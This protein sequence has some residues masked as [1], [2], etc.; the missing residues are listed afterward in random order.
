MRRPVSF[1]TILVALLAG[2]GATASPA[3][4]ATTELFVNNT[5]SCSD[6]GPGSAAQPFCTLSASAAAVTA[7]QTV[8]VTGSY[9][10][11]LTIGKSGTAGSP[12]TFRPAVDGDTSWVALTGTNAGI[13]VSGQHDVT[14]IGFQ[15][16]GVPTGTTVDV[17]N[18]TRVTIERIELAALDSGVSA[19][20]TAGVRLAS[21][22]DSALRSIRIKRDVRPAIAMDAATSGVVVTS[23]YVRVNDGSLHPGGI[24]IL[25]PHNSV[26]RS[27]VYYS[28]D[29]GI[30]VGAGATGTVLASDYV[31]GA[32]GTAIDN[33]GASGTAITNNNVANPCSTGIRVS[34]ASTGVSV[35]NNVVYSNDANP[36]GCDPAATGVGVGVYDAA[37]S[38]TTVDY[39]IVEPRTGKSLYAWTTPVA[40]L[41]AFRAV[42]GQGAH[43]L[44]STDPDARIDSG[45]SAAPGRQL[46]YFGKFPV[47]DP[48]VPNTGSGPITY[49]DRGARE[50]TRTPSAVLALTQR[51]GSEVTADASGS[52]PGWLPITSYTFD[53][54]D[55]TVVTQATPVAHHTFTVRGE[56]AVQ[57]TVKDDNGDLNTGA[58]KFITDGDGYVPVSPV[59]V[60][61]TRAKIGVDT[62]TPV[63]PGGTVTLQVAGANGLPADGVT[64]VTMNVTVTEPTANGFLSVYPD[65][66]SLPNASNLNWTPGLTVPNLVVVSVVNG[67][68]DFHNTSPGTVHVVADL[69]GYHSSAGGS[70]FA[71]LGPVRVLDTR[72]RIG[73]PTTTPI[74]PG[75]TLTL[76]VTGG[77]GVPAT[78]VTAVTM[79]VTVTQPAANGFLTVYPDGQAL[80]NASNLNWTPGLTAPNLVVVPVVNGKVAFHNTSPG[81]VHVVADLVGYYTTAGNGAVFHAQ[82]P[83]RALD[84]RSG[85]S[86]NPVGPGDLYELGV[87]G[88]SPDGAT[89][90]VLNV[91]V[92][93]PKDFGFLTVTGDFRQEKPN[94]SNLNWRPGQTVPNLVVVPLN[95]ENGRVRFYNT[96]SGSVHIVA[97][98]VGFYSR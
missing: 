84:T 10:E 81:T 53:F 46:D 9:A 54:G 37:V 65:G 25:G 32:L 51:P 69:V 36:N 76:Q 2:V 96:S 23:A 5:V 88:L 68:V 80:P 52:R 21:V 19:A 8:R 61:D 92:T 75:G 34:G 38:G 66:Q 78:G 42:S 89:A 27:V 28:V 31:T 85:P 79:N 11:H 95:P 93:E 82:S 4:A 20:A 43:D 67:K 63:A 62:T 22:T 83:Y 70:V 40:S 48:D 29:T 58:K 77:N 24:E 91:T 33:A 98:V 72:E 57:L 13:T 35:Q 87:G 55:G 18:S 97:D 26:V 90:V 15:I 45:N 12:V 16:Q 71:P 49:A 56:H 94:A 73:I 47:D 14:I 50:L 3:H 6:A 30:L 17:A 44:D 74:A 7:G 39:N 59:R 64:S 86:G 1:G 60:L 41:E